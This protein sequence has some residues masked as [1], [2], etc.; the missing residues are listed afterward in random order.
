MSRKKNR[1]GGLI[2]VR[3]DPDFKAKRVTAPDRKKIGKGKASGSRQQ[4][5]EL[6]QQQ[7][8]NS[9]K[10]D[11]RHGSKEPVVLGVAKPADKPAAK[12][13]KAKA[14]AKAKVELTPEKELAMLEAD[15]RLESLIDVLDEGGEISK[16]EQQWVDKQLARH[17]E[18]LAELGLSEEAEE[19]EALDDDEQLWRSLNSSSLD[20]YK[21]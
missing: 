10:K 3:K 16:Q 9:Q 11:P 8:A 21:D 2:G 12:P 19:A 20:Q 14:K 5:A 13:A 17:A 18:L 15:T 6:V 4:E 1:K 7:A